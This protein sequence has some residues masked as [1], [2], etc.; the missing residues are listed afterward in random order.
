MSKVRGGS[1]AKDRNRTREN[2]IARKAR[3][4]VDALLKRAEPAARGAESSE[5]YQVVADGADYR[6]GVVIGE[7]AGHVSIELLLC[8]LREDAPLDIAVLARA[9][10]IARALRGRGYALAHQ[11]D[12]WISCDTSISWKGVAQECRTLLG[13]LRENGFGRPSA[14][15]RRAE[16]ENANTEV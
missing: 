11:G 14:V 2:E 4:A 15:G 16:E 7:R 13:L 8:V 9:L 5:R 12:G 6:L 10:R 3:A 1:G